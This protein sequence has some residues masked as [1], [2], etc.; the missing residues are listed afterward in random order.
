MVITTA[1]GGADQD[2]LWTSPA[3]L[4]RDAWKALLKKHILEMGTKTVWNDNC[5]MD[6]VEDR[7]A[8]CDFEGQKGTMAELKILHS[9]MMAYTAKQAL[10]EVYPGERPYIINR[11]R[12]CRYPALC[13]RCGVVII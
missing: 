4:G 13:G 11:A 3:H 5:E 7:E 2:D 9:N 12:V 8:Q 1:V 6:G 10:H